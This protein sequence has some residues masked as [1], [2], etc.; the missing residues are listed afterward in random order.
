MRHQ[1]VR[2][3]KQSENQTSK[4]RHL[5]RSQKILCGVKTMLYRLIIS[6]ILC[7]A[8]PSS[9]NP[10]ITVRFI[11]NKAIEFMKRRANSSDPTINDFAKVH[12]GVDPKYLPMASRKQQSL[13]RYT[14]L[15]NS[16]YFACVSGQLGVMCLP[17][18]SWNLSVC[19]L[20]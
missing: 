20:S 10:S 14:V 1:T 7:Y 19:N 6:P 11:K 16:F 3:T 15:D 8:A 13:D 18:F 9:E 2:Q 12:H 17:S 4:L 5:L